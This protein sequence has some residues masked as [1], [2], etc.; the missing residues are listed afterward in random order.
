MNS[1]YY[2]YP[3]IVPKDYYVAGVWELPH[4]P[5]PQADF[6]MTWILCEK[7]S[8]GMLYITGEQHDDLNR[9]HAGWQRESFENLL[10]KTGESDKF[11]TH[12]RLS[13]DGSRIVF[14]AFMNDDGLGSSRVLGSTQLGKAFPQGYR[15][16]FP[17]RSCGLAIP[18]DITKR[19][20]VDIQKM[21]KKMFQDATTPMSDQLFDPDQFMLPDTWLDPI[22]MSNSEKVVESMGLIKPSGKKR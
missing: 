7:D 6:I 12:Y 20:L 8:G 17:D 9:E 1:S 11:F 5:F 13:E 15:I 3:L 10:G 14:I 18:N 19:E 2:I 21:L 22:D 4:R 16:A